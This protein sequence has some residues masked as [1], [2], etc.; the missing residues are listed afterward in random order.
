MIPLQRITAPG[1]RTCRNRARQISI[2]SSLLGNTVRYQATD[3]V[4]LIDTTARP[5]PILQVK[6]LAPRAGAEL[7]DLSS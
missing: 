2:S 3:L 4:P 5:H 1:T 6:Q 7:I